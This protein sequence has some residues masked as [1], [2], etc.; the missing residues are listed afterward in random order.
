[1]YEELKGIKIQPVQRHIIGG[2]FWDKI[3][4]SL[5]EIYKE[6]WWI[7]EIFGSVAVIVKKASFSTP[8]HPY[9]CCLQ[10]LIDTSAITP[11]AA[12]TIKRIQEQQWKKYKH[13]MLTEKDK[14]YKV[15]KDGK[16]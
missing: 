6:G 11:K 7:T 9:F 5:D 8:G 16:V 10:K 4:T 3:N 12:I 13:Y 2:V 15:N 14:R 1:M